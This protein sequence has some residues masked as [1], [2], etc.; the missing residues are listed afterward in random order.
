[1]RARRRRL[2]TLA[3]TLSAVALIVAV[4]AISAFRFLV[5]AVPGY[6]DD[7]EQRVSATLDRRVTIRELDLSWRRFRPSL[8]LLEVTL[9]GDDGRTPALKLRELNVGID[10]LA[11]FIGRLQ[12]A[13]VRLAGVALTVERLA[14]GSLKVSG[15]SS[16]K[17]L[18]TE[19]LRR[20]ARA[21]DRVGRVVVADGQ[22][23]WLDYTDPNT[24][25]R[26]GDIEL[27]YSS[28]GSRHR[29]RASAGL[30]VNF[31]GSLQL[32]AQADGD[33]EQFAQ[34]TVKAE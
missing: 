10:W 33:L 30:P 19:D 18:T 5:K 20:I 7:I 3:L 21:A 16:D 1:M 2:W 22:L 13:E 15:I 11:L 32:D 24:F 12:L 26:I 29:L 23:L 9:F 6:R 31:G 14:D 25:H 17:P 28:S 34:L 27:E 4:I 8:D